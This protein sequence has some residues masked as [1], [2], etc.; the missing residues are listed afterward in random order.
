MSKKMIL[1][2]LFMASSIFASA[3]RLVSFKGIVQN[4]NGEAIQNVAI[5]LL[6]SNYTSTSNTVGQFF[7]YNIPTGEYTIRLNTLG[8]TTLNQKI[9]VQTNNQTLIFKLNVTGNKLEEVIVSAEKRDEKAQN[10]PLSI[11]A[12]S[13]KKV[14]EYKLWDIKDITAIVPN[15][16][17]SNPGDNRNVTSI[18]GI[19]STSYDP[20]VATYIDGVNQFGLDTYISQ[21]QDIERIEVLNGPQGTLYGRNA[22]GG[23]INIITKAPNNL[24]N[25]FIELGYGNF[26]QQR[27]NAGITLPIVKNKLFFGAAGLYNKRNGFYTNSFNNSN[28]D[29]QHSIM[30]NYFL[31]F[32]ASPKTV[33]TLNAK[34]VANRN[35]GAFPLAGQIRDARENP[36]VLNQNSI[37]EMVDN[38]FNTAL[39]VNYNSSKFNFTSQSAYQGN[40]RYY[41]TPIDG[42]FSP[43]DGYAII[44]NYGNKWN[45]V[46]VYSQELRLSSPANNSSKLTWVAGTYLF[47]QYSPVKQGIHIGS[48]GT[49]IGAP[50]NNFTSINTNISKGNGIAF[51]GQ[52]TYAIQPKLNLIIGLRYDLENKKQNIMGEFQ[53]DGAAAMLVQ[54]DTSAKAAFHAF[55]PKAGLQYLINDKSSLYGNYSRGFRAGGISQ[56]SGDPREALIAYKPELSNN[57]EIGSKNMFFNQLLKLNVSVFYT[58]INNAQVPTLLLPDAI[59][60]TK[61][62]GK[63]SSKGFE[64]QTDLIAAKNLEFSYNF[65]YTNARYKSLDLP[66]NG[67][68]QNFKNNK[69]VFTPNFTS[70]LSANYSYPIPQTNDKLFVLAQWRYIGS[71]YFDLA[72]Q[73]KQEAFNL[74]NT[75]LGISL[76]KLELSI[77]GENIFNKKYVDYAYSFGASHLGTPRTYGLQIKTN[78]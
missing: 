75:R 17:Q 27:I 42:D 3:Q 11:T 10:L 72:N 9:N 67:S 62:A 47:Y 58:Q 29:S 7:F 45:K 36:F 16:Y 41:K 32:L 63:L 65:G 13:I 2:P 30:G 57:F 55:S 54:P 34:H 31:K 15:L 52:T 14:S 64:L 38:T 5:Q 24:S 21:L 71:Q 4:T 53:P 78:F 48:D 8:Y 22:M 33:I 74:T 44:N 6:N 25:G 19:S 77:W 1:I 28:F 69:Q 40:Y 39:S 43:L 56:L 76:K 61:N 20:S 60:V 26:S 18:R 51:F 35:K 68:V 49:L 59:T 23:V 37:A 66:N 73:L 70:F 50:A 12:L 46:N